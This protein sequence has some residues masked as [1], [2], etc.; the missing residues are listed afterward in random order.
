MGEEASELSQEKLRLTCNQCALSKVRCNKRKPTCQRCETHDF[1]CVYDRSRRRGKPR[2]SQ[3]QHPIDRRST[4]YSTQSAPYNWSNSSFNDVG[5]DPLYD[6]TTLMP[7]NGMFDCSIWTDPK[8][9]LYDS[10]SNSTHGS[11]NNDDMAID[12]ESPT[13]PEQ[14]QPQTVDSSVLMTFAPLGKPCEG[15]TC[16]STAFCSLG[17]L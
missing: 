4:P 7:E 14:Q 17:T 11:S 8:H 15:E 12:K 9:M 13:A 1:E 16:I 2:S 5:I 3:Q 10:N 6:L